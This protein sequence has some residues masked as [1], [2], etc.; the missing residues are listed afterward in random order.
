MISGKYIRCV[1][2]GGHGLVL[3]MGGEP[4]ECGDCCG[5]GSNWQYPKGALARYYGGP[6]I[7]RIKCR[8]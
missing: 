2:C 3:S 5:N 4:D 7:G 6:F 1:N 8:S